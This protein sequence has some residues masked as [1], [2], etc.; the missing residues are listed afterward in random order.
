V[1]HFKRV[2]DTFGHD[3]GDLVLIEIAKRVRLHLRTTDKLYRW[4]G[5]EFLVVASH[6][7]ADGA[8]NWRKSYAWK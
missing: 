2:N 5:E 3:V 1:D 7:D 4:G 8:R 6:T